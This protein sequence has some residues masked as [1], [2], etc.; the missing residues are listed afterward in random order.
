MKE[1]IEK[2]KTES[3][4]NQ[5]KAQQQMQRISVLSNELSDAKA[6][7]KSA[8]EKGF[9]LSQ[10]LLQLRKTATL[11][12]YRADILQKTV[13]SVSKISKE[14][15]PLDGLKLDK[16]EQQKIVE[17]RL[18]NIVT[19]VS[20]FKSGVLKYQKYIS[21]YI[22]DNNIMDK[23][24]GVI[25]PMLDIEPTYEPPAR[26]VKSR[27]SNLNPI[28]MI[29]RRLKS[30][31]KFLGKSI[32]PHTSEGSRRNISQ[33]R[34]PLNAMDRMSPN[35]SVLL[36]KRN[37]FGQKQFLLAPIEPNTNTIHF[38]DDNDSLKVPINI[39]SA[40]SD[41]AGGKKNLYAWSDQV[42]RS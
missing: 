28:K 14:K 12:A 11:D 20:I 22:H 9:S 40:D 4:A 3:S 13:T 18:D 35:N 33:L 21:N 34:M 26:E 2:Q 10:Q 1:K 24:N 17:A 15:E 31:D 36:E 6:A 42:E 23:M 38:H 27:K 8:K 37:E 41:V 30:P 25:G 19:K 16:E 7:L 29:K 5:F 32:R 39:T